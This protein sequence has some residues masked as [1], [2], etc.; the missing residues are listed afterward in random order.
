MIPREHLPIWTF[1][2][3]GDTISEFKDE[4]AFLSNF[5]LSPIWWAG[6]R[7]ATVEHLFQGLKT[8]DRAERAAI[9]CAATPAIAKKLGRQV[10]LRPDWD[11]VRHSCM[12]LAVEAKFFQNDTLGQLL[13]DTNDRILI[14]GNWWGDIIWGVDLKQPQP[15][16]FN[17]LGALL[18]Q[19]RSKLRTL[20]LG[21]L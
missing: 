21:R 5:F 17:R 18:M 19:T 11:L 16:G 9:H 6:Q 14:E 4:F 13:L 2:M 12:E 1:Q 15:E 8:L 7:W 3:G 10:T 20:G